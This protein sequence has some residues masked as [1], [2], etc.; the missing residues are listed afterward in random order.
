VETFRVDIPVS[1]DDQTTPALQKMGKQLDALI[2]KAKRV[3]AQMA[4]MQAQATQT[5]GNTTVTVSL[6]G[7]AAAGIERARRDLVWMAQR[8]HVVRVN[9]EV[10]VN[11]QRALGP[12][13]AQRMLGPSRGLA[14][15]GLFAAGFAANLDRVV[16]G[17]GR[18]LASGGGGMGALPPGGAAASGPNGPNWWRSTFALPPGRPT[19]ARSRFW[20]AG[21]RGGGFSAA[22]VERTV[23]AV[24]RVA[25]AVSGGVDGAVD[26]L[27]SLVQNLFSLR[28][29]LMT[30]VGGIVLDRAILQPIGAYDQYNRARL[31]IQ[32]TF[33]R[34]GMAGG[35]AM[36]D[37]I[38]R[39]ATRNAG[40]VDRGDLFEVGQQLAL[41]KMSPSNQRRLLAGALDQA[42]VGGTGAGGVASIASAFERT[43][44]KD[45]FGMREARSLESAKV[46]IV[47]ILA[48]GL[49]M[50]RRAVDFALEKNFVNAKDAFELTLRYF[51]SIKRDAD[52]LKDHSLP[53]LA[54][55][56]QAAFDVNVIRP[57]G[58]GLTEGIM[59]ALPGLS[60]G[61]N[62]NASA[63]ARWQARVEPIG[64]WIGKELGG[65]I[66]GLE[67]DLETLD[68]ILNS[69]IVKDVQDIPRVLR[70]RTRRGQAILDPA[71]A[72][73]RAL[74]DQRHDEQGAPTDA[75]VSGATIVGAGAQAAGDAAG[76]VSSGLRNPLAR[77]AL[78]MV[79]GGDLIATALDA[80]LSPT[81][82]EGAELGTVPQVASGA[83]AGLDPNV[84]KNACGPLAAAALARGFGL[85][86]DDKKIVQQSLEKGLFD[87]TNGTHGVAAFQQEAALAG[88]RT[89]Q[90]NRDE[91][92]AQ[93]RAGKHVAISSGAHYFEG[94]SIDA[95]GRVH[96]GNSGLAM[97]RYG[98]TADMTLDEMD[99]ASKRMSGSGI[100][101]YVGG[102]GPGGQA[103]GSI[104]DRMAAA[105]AAG[106][107]H[108]YARLA[109]AKRGVNPTIFERQIQEESGF[110]AD[111]PD[112]GAG[113]RGI[114]QLMPVHWRAVDPRNPYASLDYAAQ[115]DADAL[116]RRGGDY[117]GMLR[118]YNAG[119]NSANPY[120]GETNKY[121]NDVMSGS[122]GGAGVHIGSINVNVPLVS[123]DALDEGT[124]RRLAK[125]L[126]DETAA[127]IAKNLQSVG[128]NRP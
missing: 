33:G 92:L 80:L 59:S 102:L 113:A 22:D 61:L 73:G 87:T 116:K 75:R 98:G 21:Q 82:A 58:K 67:H 123:A 13:G 121:V 78:S 36:V 119:P 31:A 84:V 106:D 97:S 74:L 88:L 48:K 71:G 101:G 95:Q 83:L 70:E 72:N 3:E 51:E 60:A 20:S 32:G 29:A 54:A 109:A 9:Y 17:M 4:K 115:M 46:P 50:D 111:G 68:A 6:R 8:A 43:G 122:Q 40:I 69:R 14:T 120:N 1:V 47:D 57:F 104:D 64:R 16:R 24:G 126:A 23:G 107:L 12:G 28:T 99:A 27:G 35:G 63:W 7:D 66:R 26:G 127:E 89:T 108:A 49:G 93:L 41:F 15:N 42:A 118:D 81:K 79:P 53:L 62:E 19:S 117:E 96:V 110:R 105:K 52:D 90:I 77:S 128:Q 76:G 2:A 5:F 18:G 103:G 37:D 65:F 44:D 100:N 38:D 124:R 86:V 112:S 55:R 10:S 56:M 25:R 30:V 85:A 11:G 125:A 94:S 39:L 114:A 34:N 45:R 91:A